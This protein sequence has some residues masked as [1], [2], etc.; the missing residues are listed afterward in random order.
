MGELPQET[1]CAIASYL[2]K[3]DLRNFS[4]ISRDFVAESQRQLFHTVLFFHHHHPLRWARI[5]TPT[6]LIIPSYIRS[7]IGFF[8]E[9]FF[10]PPTGDGPDTC[11]LAAGMFASFVNLEEIYLR[12]LTLCNP[13]QLSTLSNLSASAQSVRSLRIEASQCS[14][15]LMVK[16]IYLFPR[17]DNLHIDAVRISDDEPYDIPTPSPSFQGRGRI[18]LT[19]DYSSHLRFLPLR[20]KQLYLTFFLFN[21][22]RIPVEQNITALNGLFVTCASTLEHLSLCGQ[23]PSSHP[24]PKVLKPT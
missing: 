21:S 13:H 19:G 22:W 23:Y 3:R 1:I 11:A 15:G 4:L 9:G 8:T 10:D 14:P 7:F 16:F 6:H 20:F 2:D 12:N 18:I 5:I 17:L 24:M